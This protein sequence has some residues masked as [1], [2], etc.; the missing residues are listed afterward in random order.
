MKITTTLKMGAIPALML[1][2][3]ATI[4]CSCQ[5]VPGTELVLVKKFIPI[6][7]VTNYG[8][9][10]DPMPNDFYE[11]E[12][13]FLMPEDNTILKSYGIKKYLKVPTNNNRYVWYLNKYK[14][15]I[16]SL[17]IQ[18]V[19]YMKNNPANFNLSNCY[20]GV[21]KIFPTMV[22]P[23]EVVV[24]PIDSS[25]WK[26]RKTFKVPYS[27]GYNTVYI[28]ACF[29]D[30]HPLAPALD[31]NVSGFYCKSSRSN[32]VGTDIVITNPD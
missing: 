2:I 27:G 29:N 18:T 30:N 12:T 26:V 7:D 5:K 25:L 6:T 15:P 21:D 23:L 16:D 24:T 32:P 22:A 31:L 9:Q 11:D 19:F 1:L 3:S 8:F 20:V 14:S 17:Y 10:V 13:F 4:F 28:G